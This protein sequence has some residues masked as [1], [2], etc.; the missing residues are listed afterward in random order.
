MKCIRRYVYNGPVTTYVNR[1]TFDE[2]MC[3]NDLYIFVPSDLDL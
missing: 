1:S 3:K 2:D